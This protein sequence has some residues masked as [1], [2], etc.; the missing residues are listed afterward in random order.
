[1]W[2]LD[3]PT[4][5]GSVVQVKMRLFNTLAMVALRVTQAEQSLFQKVIFLVPEGKRNILQ[6]VGIADTCYAVLTPSVCS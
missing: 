2:M 3:K 4:V 1:M 5:C 6:S